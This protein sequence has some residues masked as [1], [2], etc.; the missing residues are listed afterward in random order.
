MDKNKV[1]NFFWSAFVGL[2]IAITCAMIGV[3]CIISIV[4]YAFGQKYFEIAKFSLSPAGKELTTDFTDDAMLNLIWLFFGGF[5]MATMC[6]A[7][8]FVLSI[9][10]IG[11]PW[12]KQSFKIAKLCFAPFGAYIYDTY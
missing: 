4:G 11:I 1:F 12:A 9:T 3:F 5:M 7:I 8:G 6:F 10:L 2:G